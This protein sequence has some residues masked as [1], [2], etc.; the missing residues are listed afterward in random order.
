[1]VDEEKFTEENP[2]IQGHETVFESNN[3]ATETEKSGGLSKVFSAAIDY[4][5][6]DSTVHKDIGLGLFQQSLQYDQEQLA[7]DVGRVRW[8][9][10]LLVL[11]MMM[12]T[13]MLSF[14]DKMT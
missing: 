1:M 13:Y 6:G 9:L 8:K 10:D 5:K 11:P 3:V 14:L 7:R 12:T 2:R 4:G